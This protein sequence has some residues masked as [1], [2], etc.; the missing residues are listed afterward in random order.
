MQR[1]FGHILMTVDWRS[2]NVILKNFL[3]LDNLR[4][5]QPNLCL[6]VC[7]P[8]DRGLRVHHSIVHYTTVQYSTAQY[9][10][11]QYSTIQYIT[12]QYSRVQYSTATRLSSTTVPKPKGPPY[13]SILHLQPQ[14][15]DFNQRFFL[16]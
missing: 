16:M 12:V 11:I 5:F 14:T 3:V 13:I 2:Y 9:S 8:G 7:L 6:A 15:R 1:R 4:V 10:T